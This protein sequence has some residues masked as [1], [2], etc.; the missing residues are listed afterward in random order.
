MFCFLF[1]KLKAHA[2]SEGREQV[3]L[4]RPSLARGD[5]QWSFLAFFFFRITLKFKKIIIK[6]SEFHSSLPTA[7]VK[8]L[9]R[10][11]IL[12]WSLRSSG[13]N[14]AQGVGW[15][16]CGNGPD[17]GVFNTRGLQDSMAVVV[18]K[19]ALCHSKWR[20]ELRVKF[21]ETS[22]VMAAGPSL[23]IKTDQCQ[24]LYDTVGQ[25]KTFC[26]RTQCTFSLPWN[27]DIRCWLPIP[28]SEEDSHSCGT[29]LPETQWET[30]KAAGVPRTTHQLTNSTLWDK[31][32]TNHFI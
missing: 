21:L 20:N 7:F 2:K 15:Q 8:Y 14:S 18:Y 30:N 4:C 5:H 28:V 1:A 26:N 31:N 11:P 12:L 6:T 25:C 29:R 19:P 27:Q 13:I 17:P 16:V 32:L 10:L 3:Q 24:V 23:E 22:R 9:W